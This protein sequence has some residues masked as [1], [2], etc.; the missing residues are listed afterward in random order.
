MTQNLERRMRVTDDHV[1][2]DLNAKQMLAEDCMLAMRTRFG[3]TEELANKARAQLKNFD[4]VINML[5]KAGLIK[6][7]CGSYVPTE[8]GWL[9]GNE[10]YIKLI[11]LC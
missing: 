11:D 1:E 7:S 3:I 5:I 2:D 9:C 4:D 6:E 10:L 8:K